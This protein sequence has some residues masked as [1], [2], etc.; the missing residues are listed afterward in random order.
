MDKQATR[1]E[2]ARLRAALLRMHAPQWTQRDTAA[3]LD[4]VVRYAVQ[5]SRVR[6]EGLIAKR[7]GQ[8]LAAE[9]VRVLLPAVNFGSKN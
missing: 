9:V 2:E 4:E 8:K 7:V 1:E 3:V 5:G 6:V